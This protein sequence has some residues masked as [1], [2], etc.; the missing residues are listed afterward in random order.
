MNLEKI[1]KI[2]MMR[3][4]DMEYEWHLDKYYQLKSLNTK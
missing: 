2:Y 4:V 1:V 3:N